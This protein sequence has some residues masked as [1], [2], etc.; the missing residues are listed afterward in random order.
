MKQ[1]IQSLASG[2]TRIADVPVPRAGSGQLL[3]RARRSLVSAGTERMLVH[4]GRAGWVDKARQQPEK[5]REVFEKVGTDGL[6]ATVEAVRSKLNQPLALGYCNT[7]VVQEIGP[8]VHGFSVGDRVVCNGAH[9]EYVAVPR[10]LCARVPDEVPDDAAAFTVIGAIGL[11]AIRL[12][13]PTLGES[14]VVTGLGLVGLVT[15]QLLRA[16]GCRV[17]GIDIDDNR[18]RVARTFGAVT[19]NAASGEDPVEVAERFSRGRGV[20]GVLLTLASTSS[21][22]VKQAARMC[23]KRG[24]VVLVGVSGLELNR[25][26][27]YE[28]EISFQVSCSYGPGR[29]DPEYEQ[30]GRDYPIGFVRWTEQRNFEAVLDMLADDRMNVEPLISHRFPIDQ[31]DEAYEQLMSENHSLGILLEYGREEQAALTHAVNLEPASATPVS[32]A[33]KV[34]FIGAGNYGG[35]VLIPAFKSADCQLSTVVTRTSV[36]SVHYGKQ[37][38]FLRAASDPAAIWDGEDDVVVVATRHDSHAELVIRALD[39]GKHVFV[40]KPLALTME[41]LNAIDEAVDRRPDRLLM[42]GFNRRFAPQLRKIHSLLSSTCGPKSFVMT[43]NAGAILHDHWTQD[44]EVGGGRIVGEAC[45][46][47]DLL[48][49][50]AGAQIV[51][52]RRM[53]MKAH[54]DDTVSIQLRFAEGSIGTVHYFANGARSFP[55][56]RLEVF[57]GGRVLQL[58]NFRRLVGFGW[59]GFRKMRLWRQDKGQHACVKAFVEAVRQGGP[60]PIPLGEIL[61]VSRIS[62]ELAGGQG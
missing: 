37:N 33:P 53:L 7:G 49:F 34:S 35:R 5:V 8:D 62:I 48:R 28:K 13:Q 58:D 23:R 57:A 18:L 47:I 16:H 22:P 32:H 11:Q 41:E 4:F 1:V 40:E 43:V 30:K 42:V 14:F 56:E 46:F 6:A 60:P 44:R 55:K 9:A 51:E 38:G 45:H 27:F 31:A 20:D 52:A 36:G 21:E 12:A 19:V 54:T 17:M 24:R 26:D 2:E 29:H 61:E 50:L 15:V 3:I 39:A 25:A 10:N 59:P